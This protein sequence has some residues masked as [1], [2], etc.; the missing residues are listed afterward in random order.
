LSA[1]SP[2]WVRLDVRAEEPGGSPPPGDEN[3]MTLAKLVELFSRL[4]PAGEVRL[5]SDAGPFRLRDLH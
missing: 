5:H 4:Q 1:A 3:G 2:F